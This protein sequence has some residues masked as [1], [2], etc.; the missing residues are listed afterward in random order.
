[1]MMMMMIRKTL[2]LPQLL[3]AQ[4]TTL[5]TSTTKAWSQLQLLQNNH[6]SNDNVNGSINNNYVHLRGA[7]ILS[8]SKEPQTTMPVSSA[9]D[10]NI[11]PPLG[12][13]SSMIA[14]HSFGNAD[15]LSEGTSYSNITHTTIACSDSVCSKDN[16]CS[17]ENYVS[18]AGQMNATQIESGGL[19][20]VGGESVEEEDSE[21]FVEGSGIEQEAKL[22]EESWDEQADFGCMSG[23]DDEIELEQ[24]NN[25]EFAEKVK[26]SASGL[27]ELSAVEKFVENSWVEMGVEFERES[28]EMGNG[29]DEGELD[30]VV[31]GEPTNDVQAHSSDVVGIV[32]KETI[33]AIFEEGEQIFQTIHACLRRMR[34]IKASTAAQVIR[35]GGNDIGTSN[36]RTVTSQGSSGMSTQTS[37]QMAATSTHASS[38]TPVL[39]DQKSQTCGEVRPL[40]LLDDPSIYLNRTYYPPYW[41][42]KTLGDRDP[43]ELEKEAKTLKL[44]KR[45]RDM[46]LSLDREIE[47]EGRGDEGLP[48]TRRPRLWDSIGNGI[49]GWWTKK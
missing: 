5:A 39:C 17:Q 48:N 41:W 6:S 38:T 44:P 40:T 28:G 25:V 10:E 7:S 35:D 26:E 22:V 21:R 29:D 24:L 4:P 47:A 45:T 9:T 11:P 27:G 1:M 33:D 8:S 31:S 14:K 15:H 42:S 18:L 12:S 23:G 34:N 49:V 32:R 46:V 19:S 43:A 30:T 36:L 37:D 13:S 20:G 3:I 2:H 16:D